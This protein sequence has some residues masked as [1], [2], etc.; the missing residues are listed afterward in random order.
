MK[1]SRMILTAVAIALIVTLSIGSA[2][3]YFTT[4]TTVEGKAPLTAGPTTTVEEYYDGYKH[5][6]IHN[7]SDDGITVFVRAKAF[8]KYALTASGEQWTKDGDYWVCSK[9]IEA[10]DD[11]PELVI[12][13]EGVPEADLENVMQSF[14]VVVVYEAV[15]ARYHE[16]GTPYADWTQKITKVT[17]QEGNG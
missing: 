17:E 4:Y 9:P 12:A 13:I 1:K 15:P 7:T 6:I 11:A 2:M 14:N 16:D 10:G 5:I 8:S 3:A